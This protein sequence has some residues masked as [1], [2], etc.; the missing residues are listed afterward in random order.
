MKRVGLENQWCLEYICVTPSGVDADDVD[1]AKTVDAPALAAHN[2]NN[3][4]SVD[5]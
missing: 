2:T 3:H 1:G 4:L 5:P